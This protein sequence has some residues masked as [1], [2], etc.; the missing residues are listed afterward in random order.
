MHTIAE[1]LATAEHA[2]VSKVDGR[3]LLRS[4]VAFTDASLLAFPERAIDDQASERYAQLLARRAAG[5][6]VAYL[7]GK[8]EFYSLEF[9][10]TPAVLIPRSE[11]ELLVEWALERVPRERTCRVLD[12]GTGSGCVAIAIAKERPLA[13]VI[14]SDVSLDAI[15][16]A[17]AN[18]KRHAVANVQVVQSDWFGALTGLRFEVIL[19]NPPYVATGDPHLEQGDLRFE[20]PLALTAG[21]DGLACIRAIVAAAPGHMKSD[22]FVAIEHGYDQASECRDLLMRSGFVSVCTRRDLAGLERATGGESP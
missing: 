12:L 22:A 15:A 2:G 6:P 20:P 5:E 1:A 4:V 14:A 17:R 9:Q 18:V 19:A 8:R 7:T 13:E 21:E 11:T 16:V 3:A 10:V